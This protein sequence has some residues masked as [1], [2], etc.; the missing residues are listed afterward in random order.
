MRV[1]V[2]FFMEKVE[3]RMTLSKDTRIHTI[4]VFKLSVLAFFLKLST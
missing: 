1:Y 2:H 4:Y 3:N